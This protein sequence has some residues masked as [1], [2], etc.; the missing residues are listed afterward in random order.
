MEL[1][2]YKLDLCWRRLKSNTK[3]FR[4]VQENKQCIMVTGS[5]IRE[6][7][8]NRLNADFLTTVGNNR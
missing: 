7:M 6:L 4:I 5:I 3:G 8:L 1:K 2:Q